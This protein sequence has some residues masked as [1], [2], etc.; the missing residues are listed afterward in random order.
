MKDLC[1]WPLVSVVVLNY[2]HSSDT[3][4]FLESLYKS[5]YDNLE[6]IVVDNGSE[7]GEAELIKD[8]FKNVEL[9]RVEKNIGYAPANNIGVK[10]AKG[11]YIFSLNN[12]IVVTENFIFPLLKVLQDNPDIGA[13]CPK[14]YFYDEPQN[15][16]YTGYTEINP[17]TLRNKSIGYN[18][19]DNG[20]YNS[21]HITAFAH[22]GAIMFPAKL[23]EDVGHMSEYFFLY[24]E[25]MDWCKK[26][27]NAGYKICYVHNSSIYHKDSVTTGANSP[28]KTYY[29]N[30]GR[31]IYMRRHIKFPLIIISL[32]Y[33]Y[34]FAFPKNI[35]CFLFKKEYKQMKSFIRAY[36]WFIVHFFDKNMTSDPINI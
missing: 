1:K 29:L 32:L 35:I 23:I 30:R 25:D 27:R 22:G 24:Y 36:G 9:Y 28:L 14:I 31:L 33:V 11:E 15:I 16:Q 10:Q 26:I 18:E 5:N 13:V 7:P 2:N 6:V 19:P 21:D 3:I 8:K 20:Q 4:E 17:I 34:L 12:D